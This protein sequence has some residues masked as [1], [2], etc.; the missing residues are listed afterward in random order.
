MYAT[1]LAISLTILL[2]FYRKRLNSAWEYIEISFR[3]LPMFPTSR[4]LPYIR[5]GSQKDFDDAP[6]VVHCD[7]HGQ[8]MRRVRERSG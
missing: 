2:F 5:C 8:G 7:W 1:K 3:R 4:M 6:L